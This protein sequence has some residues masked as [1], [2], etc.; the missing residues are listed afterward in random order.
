M[1]VDICRQSIVFEQ[2][3]VG[4]PKRPP[5]RD[6]ARTVTA[7]SAAQSGLG[8]RGLADTANE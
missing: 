8:R 4:S 3:A 6:S 5:L 1:L 2:V 7:G